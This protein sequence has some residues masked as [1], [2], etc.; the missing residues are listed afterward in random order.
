MVSL[1]LLLL[2][3]LTGLCYFGVSILGFYAFGTS[4]SD[5]VLLAFESGPQHWVV[6]MANM[7]V[8]IHVAAAYQVPWPWLKQSGGEGTGE[9]VGRGGGA[10]LNRGDGICNGGGA[11]GSSIPGRVW[12][13][14]VC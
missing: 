4:V 12:V 6:A 8:V 11:C 2:L 14:H 7:M 9:G 13:V 10:T 1:L 5:N 3:L